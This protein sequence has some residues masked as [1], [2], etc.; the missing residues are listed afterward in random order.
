M[1]LLADGRTPA[2]A[3]QRA[4]RTLA[5]IPSKL[6]DAPENCVAN[7]NELKLI[8]GRPNVTRSDRNCVAHLRCVRACEPDKTNHV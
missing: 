3:H 4:L 5:D 2:R 6:L 8:T 7:Q 1:D